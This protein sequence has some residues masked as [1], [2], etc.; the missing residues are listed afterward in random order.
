MKQAIS[1]I[2]AI[3]LLIGSTA[4]AAE[5]MTC[6]ISKGQYVNIRNRPSKT[7]STLGDGFR[8]GDT[9]EAEEITGGWIAFTFDGEAA[10]VRTD[11]F[12]IV[13]GGQYVISGNGRVRY[14]EAPGGKKIDFYPVGEV[15]TVDAWRYDAEGGR[16]A[17][18]GDRY[19]MA[20]YLQACEAEGL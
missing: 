9:V 12:E 18:I 3:I 1:T 16:W 14:R 10:Y 13:D 6:V 17:R 15:V 8:N 2:L 19:V 20:E 7:A 4:A 5:T 11:Y